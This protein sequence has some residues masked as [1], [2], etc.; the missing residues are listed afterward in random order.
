MD[1]LPPRREMDYGTRVLREVGDGE[2]ASGQ[3]E[4]RC[5]PSPASESGALRARPRRAWRLNLA[6]RIEHVVQVRGDP[7]L[8]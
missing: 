2:R 7:Q 3:L 4:K 5:A 8:V 1:G 6:Q